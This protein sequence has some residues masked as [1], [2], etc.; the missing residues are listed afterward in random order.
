[1]ALRVLNEIN[2]TESAASTYREKNLQ[3][4]IGSLI[5]PINTFH[6][7]IIKDF[8]LHLDLEKAKKNNRNNQMNDLNNIL[9]NRKLLSDNNIL[10][11]NKINNPNN[12]NSNI[13]KFYTNSNLKNSI[14]KRIQDLKKSQSINKNILENPKI[15]HKRNESIPKDNQMRNKDD[16]FIGELREANT[17][18]TNIKNFEK[19]NLNIAIESEDLNNFDQGDKREDPNHTME[20]RFQDEVNNNENIHNLNF[21]KQIKIEGNFNKLPNDI[22]INFTNYGVMNNNLIN[23]NISKNNL[24]NEIKPNKNVYSSVSSN[25]MNSNINQKKFLASMNSNEASQILINRN[26]NNFFIDSMY[27]SNNDFLQSP[28]RYIYEAENL[29]KNV[30]SNNINNDLNL[31][32][33]C[34]L[35]NEDYSEIFKSVENQKQIKSLSQR[36][37]QLN[38]NNLFKESN[39]KGVND[40]NNLMNINSKYTNLDKIF[41]SNIPVTNKSILDIKLPSNNF[42]LFIKNNE[43]KQGN[44]QTDFFANHQN[45]F[46]LLEQQ[47]DSLKKKK[48]KTK[49]ITNRLNNMILYKNVKNLEGNNILKNIDDIKTN[50][51]YK[52]NFSDSLDK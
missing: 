39:I 9:Y 7:C 50:I 15:D 29:S 42:P 33:N 4:K 14:S 13:K 48:N 3:K 34:N 11:A 36:I 44:I 47:L 49:N 8:E 10:S 31:N 30:N 41:K 21:D 18:N 27:N 17:S 20:F 43:L 45:N 1:M 6:N 5:K 25:K 46:H 28:N 52:N 40:T 26:N 35:K 12:L 24:L 2:F 37:S 16:I 32:I 51:S 23:Y 38:K 19:L 22:N